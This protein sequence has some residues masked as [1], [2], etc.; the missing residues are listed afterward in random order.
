[1]FSNI[2]KSF[3]VV[4]GVAFLTSL[5]GLAFGYYQVNE[6]T[7]SQYVQWLRP[8]V[9]NPIQFLRVGF[10]HNASYLGGSTGL[11]SGIIYLVIYKLRGNKL[12]QQDA[13]SGDTA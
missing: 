7:L 12:G 6:Q 13:A 10:M 9:T 2:S 1:M 3:L 8:G 5:A 11:L 4:I